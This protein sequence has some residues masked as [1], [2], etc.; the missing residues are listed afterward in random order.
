MIVSIVHGPSTPHGD[1]TVGVA[2]GVLVAVGVIGVAVG[3]GVIGV[4]LG[5][6]VPV[7]V[8]VA[9]PVGEE[10]DVGET[11][12]VGEAVADFVGVGDGVDVGVTLKEAQG[13]NTC[14]FPPTGVDW[15]DPSVTLL[16]TSG[17]NRV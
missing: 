2:V 10:V 6:T 9:V 15:M 12:P 7:G 8:L 4:G 16:A 1:P 3:D 11:V 17:T 5:E 14:T 13:T